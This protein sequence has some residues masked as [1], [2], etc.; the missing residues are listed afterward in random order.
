MTLTGIQ[1]SSDFEARYMPWNSKLTNTVDS[2]CLY[3]VSAA[4]SC[5]FA[6][7]R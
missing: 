3:S 4:H 5:T 1:F 2:L 7:F 6:Q